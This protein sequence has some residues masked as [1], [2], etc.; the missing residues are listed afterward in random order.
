MDPNRWKSWR[1][2]VSDGV[3]QP[4][5]LNSGVSSSS[6]DYHYLD[7]YDSSGDDKYQFHVRGRS[8]GHPRLE[9]EDTAGRGRGIAAVVA[10]CPLPETA[11]EALAWL[12]MAV[13]IHSGGGQC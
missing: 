2:P 4:M 12:R 1:V 3:A 6:A 7:P 11:E 9:L 10:S 5:F 13:T 8:T